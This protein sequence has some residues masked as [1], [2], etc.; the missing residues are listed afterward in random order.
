[1]KQTLG[2]FCKLTLGWGMVFLGVVGWFLPLLPGT[3]F[4]LLGFALLSAQSERLRR[5][6]E[7][8]KIYFSGYAAKLHGLKGILISKFRKEG[9]SP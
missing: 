7:G 3:L 1:M 9:E 8:W 6:I 5:W 4:L 2:R